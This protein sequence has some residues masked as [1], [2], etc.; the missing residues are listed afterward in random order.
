[1]HNLHNYANYATLCILE[2]GTIGPKCS[3]KRHKV[4]YAIMQVEKYLF[5]HNVHNYADYA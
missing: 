2:V 1:M 4:C 3:G 5:Q